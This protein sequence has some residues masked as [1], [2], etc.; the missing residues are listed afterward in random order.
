MKS[1]NNKATVILN[2][3]ENI[4]R[5]K[6]KKVD[7]FSFEYQLINGAGLKEYEF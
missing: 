2:K 1:V 5:W 6:T 3:D 7:E 4:S